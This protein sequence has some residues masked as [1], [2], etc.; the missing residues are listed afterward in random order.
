MHSAV[1]TIAVGSGQGRC[2][3]TG[4]GRHSHVHD[5]PGLISKSQHKTLASDSKMTTPFSPARARARARLCH[6]HG[7]H[8]TADLHRATRSLV[9][10]RASPHADAIGYANT[11][12]QSCTLLTTSQHTISH[13]ESTARR[14]ASTQP[15]SF[16][17]R[18]ACTARVRCA[19]SVWMT[20][21]RV[22]LCVWQLSLT[23]SR[24]EGKVGGCSAPRHICVD[25]VDLELSRGHA[26]AME[27]CA[28][29]SPSPSPSV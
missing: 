25:L 12:V 5:C 10:V 21:Q 26:L 19:Q 20:V 3:A 16:H 15:K 7:A 1:R 2:R 18:T 14:V 22:A 24:S 28:A 6:S 13:A 11:T 4:A 27:V 8:C 23:S 29:P 9:G 17:I